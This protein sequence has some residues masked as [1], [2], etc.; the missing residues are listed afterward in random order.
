MAMINMYNVD[1]SCCYAQYLSWQTH[2]F[3]FTYTW[4]DA[5]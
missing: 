2:T 3:I 4:N 1:F 5:M